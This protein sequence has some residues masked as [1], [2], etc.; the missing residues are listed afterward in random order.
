[1][2]SRN[3]P[4]LSGLSTNAI[5]EFTCTSNRVIHE[6]YREIYLYY[7]GY[8]RML[9][10][11]LPVPPIGLF[12]S[13]IAK[14]TYVDFG[15]FALVRTNF[16]CTEG[17]TCHGSDKRTCIRVIS[18]YSSS[19]HTCMKEI[20]LFGDSRLE[21]RRKYTFH[22]T[23]VGNSRHVGR[24]IHLSQHEGWRLGFCSVI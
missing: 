9:S 19:K 11:N 2:L 8:L 20:H 14:F 15:S 5:A 22:N 21:G 13:V 3:L 10:Q 7:Q 18:C 16:T 23:R 6:C 1:M 17:I 4:I 12:T 24:K